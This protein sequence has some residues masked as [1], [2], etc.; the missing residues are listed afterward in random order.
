MI[1]FPVSSDIVPVMVDFLFKKR[2][3]VTGHGGFVGQALCRILSERGALVFG[4]SRKGGQQSSL[5]GVHEVDLVDRPAVMEV[6][7]SVRPEFV[8]HLAGLKTR[9]VELVDYDETYYVNLQGSVN[10]IEACAGCEG[11]QAFV[12]MGSCEEYGLAEVPFTEQMREEPVTAY[13]VT[14]LAVTQLLQALWR[15]R[16]FPAVVL[17]PSVIYGPGQQ[18]DMFLPALIRVLLSG[19][20]FKMSA[21]EQTRD[22][23]HV[24]D[25]VSGVLC[26]LQA[27]H[28]LGKVINLSSAKAVR[29]RDVALSVVDLIG[30]GACERLEIGAL[31]YRSGESMSYWASNALARA[32]LGWVPRVS[33]EAGLEQTVTYFQDRFRGNV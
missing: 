33:L 6:V 25:I 14:K 29:I 8:V 9:G 22:Y 11:L 3:L 24:E 5:A 20:R 15:G 18:D 4:M 17:R 2:V 7:R 27:P 28:V 16:H 26:A 30:E 19:A 10:L 23:V 32:H 13:A 21:G 31:K 12:F 1:P